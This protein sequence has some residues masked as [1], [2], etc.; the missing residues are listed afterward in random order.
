MEICGVCWNLGME[1]ME[2]FF[3]EEKYIFLLF[4]KSIWVYRF[5]NLNWKLNVF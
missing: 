4:F 3:L 2:N 1:I 5:Y